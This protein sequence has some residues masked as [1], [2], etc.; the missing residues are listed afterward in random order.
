MFVGKNIESFGGVGNE[1][2]YSGVDAQVLVFDLKGEERESVTKVFELQHMSNYTCNL[3]WLYVY[4]K[5]TLFRLKL[6]DTHQK[7]T[8]THT[9]AESNQYSYTRGP[10]LT[11][12]NTTERR[13]TLVTEGSSRKSI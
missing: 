6:H 1:I 12:C 9:H 11:S 7:C 2:T 5:H 4:C 13:I 8:H 10:L 3:E